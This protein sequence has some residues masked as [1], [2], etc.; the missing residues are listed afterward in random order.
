[1]TERRKLKWTMIV[2]ALVVLGVAGYR[3]AKSPTEMGVPANE[4]RMPV[5]NPPLEP[6]RP[7]LIGE[8]RFDELPEDDPE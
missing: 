6:D 7:D 5:A 8:P 2:F 4:L 1:M 3:A